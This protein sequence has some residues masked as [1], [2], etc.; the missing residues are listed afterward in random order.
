[1]AWTAP[2]DSVYDAEISIPEQ[3][4]DK[5]DDIKNVYALWAFRKLFGL[6][7]SPLMS[8]IE[9]KFLHSAASLFSCYYRSSFANLNVC[10][11]DWEGRHWNNI[12]WDIR[13]KKGRD[14]T[15]RAMFYTYKGWRQPLKAPD[16]FDDF[17][18]NHFL[19][20]VWIIDNR[21]KDLQ[22]IGEIMRAHTH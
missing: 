8:N 3:W 15:D 13:G 10:D 6:I 5:P 16:S 21:G 19:Q 1:M 20:G 9:F 11:H 14:F 12:L 4:L 7:D 2:L 22:E 18:G 17:F